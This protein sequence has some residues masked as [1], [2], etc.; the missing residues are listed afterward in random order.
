MTARENASMV[1]HTVS[2]EDPVSRASRRAAQDVL[3]YEA[4]LRLYAKQ[5]CR[6]E[7]D[8]DCPTEQPGKQD[9]WCTPCAARFI[10][11]GVAA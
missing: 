7:P 11:A 3:R 1:L 5:L 8:P 4:H 10:L 9:E 6:F 2:S